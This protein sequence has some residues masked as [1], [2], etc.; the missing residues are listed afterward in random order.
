[1]RSGARQPAPQTSDFV[2]G[3]LCLALDWRNIADIR[4]IGPKRETCAEWMV[5]NSFLVILIL[6]A[7]A[8][9]A[10]FQYFASQRRKKELS[11]LAGSWGFS[12]YGED[13]FDIAGKYK[14]FHAVSRGHSP[15]A[16]DVFAGDRHGH[17]TTCFD[18]RYT[19]GS[20]KS[21]STHHLSGAL[22]RHGHPFPEL[23]VRPENLLDK[24]A[25]F[26]GFDDINFESAEFSRTFYVKS[27][28]RKFAFDLFHARAME[29]ML[30]QPRRYAL[31]FRGDTVLITDDSVW[32]PGEFEPAIAQVEGLLELMPEYLK[33]ALKDGSL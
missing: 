12:W 17:E 27:K 21:Q 26:V 4:R 2:W 33:L 16:Y 7:I 20:G 30:A 29:Y 9:F 11:D 28:D 10:I 23:L 14:A 5:M 25:E 24:L 6:I 22:L 15:R 3:E 8:A 31:E 1:M 18:Y 19:T 32:S 13:P